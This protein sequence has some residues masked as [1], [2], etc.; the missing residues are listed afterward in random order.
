V[1]GFASLN[2]SYDCTTIRGA[3]DLTQFDLVVDLM[4]EADGADGQDHLGRQLLVTLEAAGRERIAHGLLDL[5][6]R[7]DADLLQKF[8]QARVEQVF[9]HDGLQT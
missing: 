3:F 8:S 4:R 5:A 7:A 9:I 1:M 6:L 2:P